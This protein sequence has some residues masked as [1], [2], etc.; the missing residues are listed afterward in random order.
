MTKICVPI[1]AQN[2]AEARASLKKI[3]LTKAELAELWLGELQHEPKEEVFQLIANAKLPLLV[4]CKGA[5]EKGKFSGT[6]AEKIDVLLSAITTGAR[7]VDVSADTN[8]AEYERL[9]KNKQQAE[10]I[11]SRHYW[12]GTP[13]LPHLT[14]EVEKIRKFHPDILKFVAT[15][16][17]FRDVVTMIRLAEKLSSKNIRHIVVAMGPLG[18][19]TRIASPLLQNEIMFAP[20]TPEDCTAPGQIPQEDLLKMFQML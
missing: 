14:Q 16:K 4:T 17:N 18:K 3:E 20:L 19:I 13:G 15:P 12:K 10:I 7:F 6:D 5:D 1:S 8:L 9:Q 11:I 2:L